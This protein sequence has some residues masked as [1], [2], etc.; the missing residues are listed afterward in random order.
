MELKSYQ[1]KVLRDL[2]S[3]LEA[4]GQPGTTAASAYARHWENQGVAIGMGVRPY[5]DSLD[6]APHICF[7]VPTGGGKTFLACCALLPMLERLGKTGPQ[8][9][10]WLVPSNAILS[11]TVKALQDMRHPYR[12]RI[13]ADFS[14]R[15]EVYTKEQLLLGQNFNPVS[16]QEQLSICVL[17]YDSLRAARKDGRL[18]YRENSALAGFVNYYKIPAETGVEGA[19]ETSLMQALNLLNP[20]VVV[21]ESHN[22]KSDL[23]VEMLQNLNPSFVLDLTATPRKN[24]N[25]ISFVDAVALKKEEMVKL[26]VIVHNLNSKSDVVITAIALQKNLEALA[27]KEQERGGRYLR[28]IVL[29]QAQTKAGQERHTYRK[30]KQDLIDSGIPEA[31]VK[32]KT[33]D[34]DEIKNLELL[35]PECP[36]RFIITVNA[37]KEGWDCSFAYVL[38]TVAN[39][40]SAV[41]VEQIVGRVLRQPHARRFEE[42]LLNN[43]YVL[44]SSGDFA[45]TLENVV[46]GL[47]NAG[48]SRRDYV[49][50]QVLSPLTSPVHEPAAQVEPE[51]D[52]LDIQRIKESLS[53]SEGGIQASAPALGSLL[54]KALEE[55]RRYDQD[56]EQTGQSSPLPMEVREHMQHYKMQTQFAHSVDQLIIPHFVLPHETPMLDGSPPKLS[57]EWLMAGFQL[58]VQDALIEF[59][60]FIGETA[61]V[62]AD[63]SSIPR[64][65]HYTVRDSARIMRVMQESS[66]EGRLEIIKQQLFN[67]ISQRENTI[68]DRDIKEY[69]ARV[70]NAMDEGTKSAL[71]N[72]YHLFA[73][74]IKRK[75]EA[76]KDAY[77]QTR[78]HY[79]LNIGDIAC[80]AEQGYQLPR[81]ISFPGKVSSI[82]KALYTSEDGDINATEY[83]VIAQMSALPNI[84]WWHR[85][86][87]RRGFSL[88]GFITHYPDFILYTKKRTLILLEVKGTQL[89]NPQSKAKVDL[90]RA[91]Q[92]KLGERYKYLMVFDDLTPPVDGAFTLTTALGMAKN[93]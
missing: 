10:V 77:R 6:G 64:V 27:H 93:W 80:T 45:M 43:A 87:E 39:R 46:A 35:S 48:F 83:D 76:L 34:V 51:T 7:K 85:N 86:Q 60:P 14:G 74:Q 42:G 69:I 65:R 28:P 58:G 18:V 30:L 33:G 23:S 44:T 4:L 1:Q 16:V 66:A 21:D 38:A 24:S 57:K 68:P 13:Q 8:V 15:V 88:N 62:D 63:E 41:E 19:D 56:I 11:Q 61:Q 79:L 2:D 89:A 3:Y 36:V 52:Q 47:N 26:P 70:V 32:I 67:L 40:T 22:A 50:P 12:R 92:D 84:L 59:D 91:W 75:I 49:A 17:S 54:E 90:G 29:F 20:V 72:H 82:A 73:E 53:P 78:F 71:A 25:I 81:E 55:G 5:R 31:Q 37:L 9:V